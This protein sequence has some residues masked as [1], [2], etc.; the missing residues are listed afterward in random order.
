PGQFR[1][2]TAEPRVRSLDGVDP[3]VR[4][5]A[6]EERHQRFSGERQAHG[7]PG[8]TQ[9]V[10]DPAGA[11]R[12][13]PEP[14]VHALEECDLFRLGLVLPHHDAAIPRGAASSA[15]SVAYGSTVP[16]STR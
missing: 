10:V 13:G 2:P 5:R 15:G 14:V 3:Q 1:G 9:V 4:E 7:G 16:F 6:R 11:L 12:R 8:Y